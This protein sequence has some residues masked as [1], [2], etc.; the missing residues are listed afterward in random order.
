GQVPIVAAILLS[1]V[2]DEFVIAHPGHHLEH[3]QLLVVIGGPVLFLLAEFLVFWRLTGIP[4]LERLA[5]AI[6]LLAVGWLGLHASAVTTSALVVAVLI[7]VIIAGEARTRRGGWS[8]PAESSA[9]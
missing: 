4:A 7:L 5:G 8:H 2:G 3:A 6:L 1:A 9:A